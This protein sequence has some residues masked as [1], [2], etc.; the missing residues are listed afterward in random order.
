MHL[1]FGVIASALGSV[2]LPALIAKDYTAVTFL[3]LAAEQFRNIRT[4]ERENLTNIEEMELVK[5]G[6]SYIEEIAK[7]FEARNYIVIITSLSTSI[8][9]YITHRWYMGIVCGTIFLILLKQLMKGQFIKEIAT[10]EK[11]DVTFKDSY[12]VVGNIVIMNIGL[13]ASK[14]RILNEGFGIVLKP[15]DENASITLS[16][17]GQRQAIIHDV[18][19]QMGIRK[20]VDEPDFTPLARRDTNSGNVAIIFFPSIKNENALIRAVGLSPVLESVRRKPSK[21]FKAYTIHK[22]E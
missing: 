18:V 8:A 1:A 3:T 6:K 21:S 4:M 16:N 9:F 15:K 5:R 7:I 20:D 17:L 14:E 19:A 12:L 11:A 2:A 10:I 22:E 13:S